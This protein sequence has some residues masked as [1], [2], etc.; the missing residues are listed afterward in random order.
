M[1][2]GRPMKFITYELKDP[3]DF[4]VA[5]TNNT[6]FRIAVNAV[7]GEAL[8][9]NLIPASA[10]DAKGNIKYG[11]L[12]PDTL[13]KYA[14][15]ID[16]KQGTQIKQFVIDKLKEQFKN[17]EKTEYTLNN[18]AVLVFSGNSRNV[19]HEI[20]FDPETNAKP[21]ESGFPTLKV[22]KA[23][24][25]L[26]QKDNIVSTNDY[27]MVFTLRK[28]EGETLTNVINQEKFVSKPAI[29]SQPTQTNVKEVYQ[30][31]ST[32]ENRE[33]NYFT[34]N[35]AEAKDYGENVR[36]VKLDT[37]GF[38]KSTDAEYRTL[39]DEFNKS[40]KTFDILD[41][42][43]EGLAIQNDFFRFLK[44]KGYKGIDMLSGTDSKYAVSF[45]STETKSSKV[46]IGQYVKF[47]GETFIVTKVNA[48]GT[49]Q[50]YNPL[51]EGTAAKKSVAEKNLE[52][53]THKTNIVTY[54]ATDYIVTS[55]G[56]I[57]S[58]TTNKVQKWGEEN[59]DRKA[60]LALTNKVKEETT[61]VMP[62][63]PFEKIITPP[64]RNASGDV[65]TKD[66]VIDKFREE[67]PWKL[68]STNEAIVTQYEKEKLP[69]ETLKEFLNR[70]SC[71]GKLI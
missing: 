20:V 56:I 49:I 10:K 43:K 27:R 47:N 5:D 63:K 14:E 16:K 21:M 15:E 13:L 12:T 45:E 41:N 22:N 55:K 19:F 28:V 32:L 44:S 50:V 59:G 9:L 70:L 8:K 54:K 61:S 66:Q 24:K 11:H 64:T 26:G 46:T 38:L 52:V 1:S 3:N 60:I 30:G 58:L 57:I 23:F 37:T 34:S 68:E 40:G 7:Q 33:F 18:G 31:Y 39:V 36:Q 62:K 42:S 4:S 71:L 35:Q 6:A 51:K 69:T 25:G 65:M 17:A 48:N 2:I 29:K 53:L 67:L